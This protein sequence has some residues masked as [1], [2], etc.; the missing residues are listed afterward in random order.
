MKQKSCVFSEISGVAIL[1]PSHTNNKIWQISNYDITIHVSIR[2]WG[3]VKDVLGSYLLHVCAY[4]KCFC[5]QAPNQ[6][7]GGREHDTLNS[8]VITTRWLISM[9]VRVDRPFCQVYI[10]QH[11][12]KAADT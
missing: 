1:I 12:L 2:W 9:Y 11:K 7:P 6:Q 5:K 10:G 8:T 4:M 3:T